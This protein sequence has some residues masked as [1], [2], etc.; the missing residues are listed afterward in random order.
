M[1]RCMS[2]KKPRLK[3]R[4]ETLKVISEKGLTAV[5]GGFTEGSRY[6][7]GRYYPCQREV[8]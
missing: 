2:S 5:H 1:G 3:L 8:D 7:G 4:K 6:I